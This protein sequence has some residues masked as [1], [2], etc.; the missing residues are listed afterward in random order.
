MKASAVELEK[1]HSCQMAEALENLR[2]LSDTHEMKLASVQEAAQLKCKSIS[3][4]N[5]N[6]T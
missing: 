2:T 3:T 1:T 6:A 4:C 5:H